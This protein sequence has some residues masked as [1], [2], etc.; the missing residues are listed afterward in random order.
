MY[1]IYCRRH[2]YFDKIMHYE[3]LFLLNIFYIKTQWYLLINTH[4]KKV[5]V[6]EKV[7]HGSGTFMFLRCIS[8]NDLNCFIEE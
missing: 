8:Y 5:P 3:L 6:C 1:I 2:K 4:Q 7:R